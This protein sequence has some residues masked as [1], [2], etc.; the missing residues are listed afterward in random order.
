MYL[1]IAV[2]E[3]NSSIFVQWIGGTKDSQSEGFRAWY[4]SL[5]LNPGMVKPT[6][7][8]ISDLVSNEAIA[9]NLKDAIIE[10]LSTDPTKSIDDTGR[11]KRKMGMLAG[12][13]SPGEQIQGLNSGLGRYIS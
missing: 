10:Y 13:P 3:E 6:M 8:P 12:V 7:T 2:F 11:A 4:D 9:K 5:I 1:L